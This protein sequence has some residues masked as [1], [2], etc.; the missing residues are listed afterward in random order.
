[1][2]FGFLHSRKV[3]IPGKKAFNKGA[4]LTMQDIHVDNLAK[5]Q[6]VQVRI[7]ASKTDHFHQ[8]VLV[9]VGRTNQPLCPVSELLV[10]MVRRATG[11]GPCSSSRMAGLS[12]GYVLPLRSGRLCWQLGLARSPILGIFSYWG[13]H[14]CCSAKKKSRK[15]SAYQLYIKTPRDHLASIS[16]KQVAQRQ[17]LVSIV[18]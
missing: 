11:Q 1:M 6:S 18:L 7:K 2:F 4:H 10:Y 8:G 5:P 12:Q 16:R 17:Q 13:C 9:Y 15:S 3:C 14:H